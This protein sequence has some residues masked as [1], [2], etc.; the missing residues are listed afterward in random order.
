LRAKI[1]S[2][3]V[4]EK[5]GTSKTPIQEAKF[6]KE[7]GIEGDAHAGLGDR[8]VSL[9]AIESYERFKVE[10]GDEHCLK[11]GTFGENI[12]TQG[13][14][15]HKLPIGIK[16][17]SE[18]VILEVSK[19]GKECHMPCAIGKKTG[20]CIMPKEG[21]FARVLKGGIVRVGDEIH[22]E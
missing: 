19:I 14:E 7:H 20:D 17:K 12:I 1:I 22:I 4:S 6:I 11:H 8:Q 2:I 15:L 3:N 5:K 13:V 9:L 18:D 21:I 16:L 10:R